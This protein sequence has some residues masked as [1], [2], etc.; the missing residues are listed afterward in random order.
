MAV[1]MAMACASRSHEGEEL[2]QALRKILP[3]R[4]E[5]RNP[6]EGVPSRANV[7]KTP[8]RA[9]TRGRE[10]LRISRSPLRI[11]WPPSCVR[12]PSIV[13]E[14]TMPKKMP[15]ETPAPETPRPAVANEPIPATKARRGFAAISPE[16]QREIASLGGK[17]A[18]AQGKAHEFTPEQARV[19]GR[20]GGLTR[21]AKRAAANTKA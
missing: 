3:A 17:A 4:L 6:P 9:T 2:R 10:G 18:H 12:L 16:K 20:K 8:R 5:A 14:V 13:L 21:A 19:A 15:V 1:E 11:I 7:R